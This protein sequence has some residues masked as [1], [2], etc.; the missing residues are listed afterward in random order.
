MTFEQHLGRRRDHLCES[1]KKNVFC[2]RN[3]KCSDSVAEMIMV[4]CRER[5]KVVTA[6]RNLV[7]GERMEGHEVVET[8]AKSCSIFEDMFKS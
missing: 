7:V 2:G 4:C 6:P 8:G 5:K 1:L 3:G